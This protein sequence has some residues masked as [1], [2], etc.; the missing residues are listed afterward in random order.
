LSITLDNKTDSKIN[1]N[2]FYISE[3]NTYKKGK[4]EFNLEKLSNGPH[5]IELKA[6]DIMNNSNI[7]TLDFIVANDSK[8][9]I[10]HLLNYP[11]PFTE[12]TTFYFNHNKPYSQI[13][14]I[15]QI[16]TPSGKL[17]KTL[18][19]E[20]YT[21]SFKS[22]P[23]EWDGLDDFGNKI[24]RGVYIYRLKLRSNKSE[25]AELIEKLVILK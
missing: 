8:L 3:P 23:I 17:V 13:E 24:G 16:Y 21:D 20:F 2:E 22:E 1:I 12:H 5:S 11:N 6:W 25:T 19:K 9:A 14:A 10:Q 4:V 18:K 7:N 15:I